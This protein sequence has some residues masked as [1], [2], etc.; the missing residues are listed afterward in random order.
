MVLAGQEL[1][2]T[3]AG[4]CGL[5]WWSWAAKPR[6]GCS[7]DGPGGSSS[8]EKVGIAGKCG[9]EEELDTRDAAALP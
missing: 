8:S 6:W 1:E 3:N 4:V 2:R 5:G 9:P 7:G